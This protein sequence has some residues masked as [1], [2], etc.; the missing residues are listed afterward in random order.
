[1]VC[2]QVWLK[3]SITGNG[4]FLGKRGYGTARIDFTEGNGLQLTPVEDEKY[5]GLYLKH[6]GQIYRGEG[7]LLGKNSPF[8]NFPILGLNI[9]SSCYCCKE[10]V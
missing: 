8:K 7:I 3:K 1:M 10:N 2:C 9:V 6:E 5:N 4:L